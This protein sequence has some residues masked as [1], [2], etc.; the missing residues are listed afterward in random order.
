MTVSLFQLFQGVYPFTEFFRYYG[1]WSPTNCTNTTVHWTLQILSDLKGA[2][3][4]N[5]FTTFCSATIKEVNNSWYVI[6]IAEQN[7]HLKFL[8][9][10]RCFG[11]IV[12]RLEG[13]MK[14]SEIYK[15][16]SHVSTEV[17]VVLHC[18]CFC[19]CSHPLGSSRSLLFAS[20]GNPA[21]PEKIKEK[22][23]ENCS[24]SSSLDSSS[25]MVW[26]TFRKCCG[27]WDPRVAQNHCIITSIS[28]L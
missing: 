4:L 2:T 3:C 23:G 11:C 26:A 15:I 7:T 27:C 20:H 13:K 1:F 18:F 24:H 25:F 6:R 16:S 12:K 17:L 8:W 28:V 19:C 22:S 14:N 5:S 9:R 21:V 10:R